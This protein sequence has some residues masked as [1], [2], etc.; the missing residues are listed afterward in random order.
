MRPA[1]SVVED[2]VARLREALL[3]GRF[4]PGQR[5]VE[6]DLVATLGVSRS[7]VRSALER[8]AAEGLVRLSAHRGAVARRMSRREV[9]ELYAI[10]ERLEGLAAGLAAERAA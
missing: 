1:P 9:E 2:A 10:R 6:A 4:A 8:L 7:S 5:L 3:E